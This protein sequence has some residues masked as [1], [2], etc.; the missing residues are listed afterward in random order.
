MN[1]VKGGVYIPQCEGLIGTFCL[2][3]IKKDGANHYCKNIKCPAQ[4]LQRLKHFCKVM[5]IEGVG[6][7]SLAVLITGQKKE[8]LCR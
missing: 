5:G 1:P 6:E 4:L 7:S 2:Q 3:F 8:V